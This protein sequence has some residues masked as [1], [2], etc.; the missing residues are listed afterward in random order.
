MGKKQQQQQQNGNGE[1]L[2]HE[3]YQDENGH[4]RVHEPNSPG[5]NS[6]DNPPLSKGYVYTCLL[7]YSMSFIIFGSQV[8]ILGPTIKPLADRLS[9][10]E[11]DLS[12]LFTALGVSCIVS[13]TPSGWLVDRLPTHNVL[14]GSL[15]VEA[16]GFALVPWM[17]SVATLTALFFLICFTYNFT[18]SAVFTSL[19][20]MFPKRAGSALNLVLAMFGVGSFLLPLATQIC[21]SFFGSPLMVFYVVSVGAALSAVPF[22]FVASPT[23]PPPQQYGDGESGSLTMSKQAQLLSTVVTVLAVVLVFCT[24]AA[25]TAVGNWLYTYGVREIGLEDHEAAFANSSFWGFFTIGRALGAALSSFVSPAG[26]MLSATPIAFIGTMLPIFGVQYMPGWWLVMA[27]ACLTGLGNSTGY[28]NAL[29]MLERYVPVTGFINGVFGMVAGG[30]CMVG[31]TTVAMLAKYTGLG[32]TAMAYVAA[33]FYFLHYP[34]ILTAVT[35]GNKLLGLYM[36][37]EVNVP[38]EEQQ[39]LTDAE[40][41]HQPLMGSQRGQ[42]TMAQYIEGSSRRAAI[43]IPASAR[44]PRA[45]FQ[46]GS[47]THDSG[48]D[49]LM[50]RG[51]FPGHARLAGSVN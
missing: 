23:P 36:E 22:L 2:L 51:S 50:Q 10:D 41:A 28:A 4:T 32:Y 44:T 9:V 47:Y 48:A 3:H 6:S 46:L 30:A 26:L 49:L 17:P 19:G 40:T 42:R 20:W 31:P 45:N 7:G 37:E 38:D 34:I 43:S 8:S 21:D 27:T 18:N 33:I 29:S 24:T 1:P 39:P 11:P 35:L 16:V 25:E 5:S 14:V 13:G 12:P 15:V